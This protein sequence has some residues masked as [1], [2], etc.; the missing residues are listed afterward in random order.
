MPMSRRDL[1]ASGVLAAGLGAAGAAVGAP[2]PMI[3]DPRSTAEGQIKLG[4]TLDGS[5][6][7]W[8]YSG[9]IYAVRPGLRPLPILTL[10]GG[11]SSWAERQPNGD[12][13]VR[14]AIL[15]FFRDPDSNAFLDTFDNP[16]TGKRNAVKAN[17][18]SGGGLIYPADGSSARLDGA[19]KAGVV[20]PKG[21][22]A[23]DPHQAL[24]AVRWSEIGSSVML[25]T[26]R[27][28]NVAVQPQLEAQTQFGDRDAFFDPRVRKIKASFSATTIAPWMAWMEMGDA[29]GHLVWHS[30]GEKV[31]TVDDMPADYRRRAGS[32]LDLL[33]TRPTG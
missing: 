13:V 29:L 17:T 14:G 9:V 2:P 23:A 8:V 22:K 19:V 20:A 30:S 18:L 28:W 4:A 7:F 21:F 26:D 32:R 5:P 16:L 27:A 15:T 11:Q 12:Y 31:F 6:A 33:A 3:D 10:A 1:I 24:G 25:M